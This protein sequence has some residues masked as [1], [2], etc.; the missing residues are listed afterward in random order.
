MKE[1]KI[2]NKKWWSKMARKSLF[3]SNQK[4]GERYYTIYE[5]CMKRI[6]RSK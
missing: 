5:Y 2:I 6:T 3:Y 4:R 1:T